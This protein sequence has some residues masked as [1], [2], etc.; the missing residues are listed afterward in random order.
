MPYGLDPVYELSLATIATVSDNG[1][2]WDRARVS[3]TGPAEG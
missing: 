1:S 2:A 3:R